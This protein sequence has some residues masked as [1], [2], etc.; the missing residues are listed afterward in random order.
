MK[1]VGIAALKS[2][3]ERCTASPTVRTILWHATCHVN[4]MVASG[5]LTE[6]ICV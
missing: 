6:L 5:S 2:C 4:H 1:Y 3:V